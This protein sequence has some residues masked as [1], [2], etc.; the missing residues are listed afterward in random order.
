[1][2]SR[3]GGKVLVVG[4]EERSPPKSKAKCYVIVKLLT[5]SCTQNH[6]LTREWTQLALAV[7]L[8]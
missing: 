2:M 5:L 3:G 8:A 6:K 1:M 4:L 7:S